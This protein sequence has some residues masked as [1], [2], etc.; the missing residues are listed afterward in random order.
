MAQVAGH[1]GGGGQLDR[2][3]LAPECKQD[4]MDTLGKCE[5]AAETSTER[6]PSST[7]TAGFSR[8]ATWALVMNRLVTGSVCMEMM[9][10]GGRSE[11]LDA[12]LSGAV[13][14]LFVL[15]W[16]WSS[17]QSC[18][19][20]LARDRNHEPVARVGRQSLRSASVTWSRDEPVAWD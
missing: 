19:Q 8:R 15:T 13:P 6:R 10:G 9:R 16:R 20:R 1:N 17:C 7:A 18:R 14:R 12:L 3:S 11:K 5:R 2:Q 4:W